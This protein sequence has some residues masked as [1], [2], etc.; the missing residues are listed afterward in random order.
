MGDIRNRCV[1]KEVGL[2]TKKAITGRIMKDWKDSMGIN[3]FDSIR[4]MQEQFQ[5]SL[6]PFLKQQQMIADIT[7]NSGLLKVQEQMTR[8]FSGINMMSEIAKSMKQHS[9]ITQPH[10]S[11]IDAITKSISWQTKFAI[12]QN[13][14]DAI[15]SI[16]RQHEK[17]FGN[18][19]AITDSGKFQ[20]PAITQIN[21]L[22]I[23]LGGISGQLAA[24]A[25]QQKNWAIL[26]DFD[27]VTEQAFE[28][29]ETLD[30]SSEAEQQRQFQI[31]LSLVVT[32]YNKHKTLGLSSLRVIEIFLIVAGLH[33]YYD[34]IQ[35][36]PELATKEDVKQIINGQDSISDFIKI[37][38]EQLKEAKEYRITNRICKV[39]LKPK[40]KTLTLTELPINFDVIVIQIHHKWVYVSYFDPK[41]NLPQ[42]GWIMKKY[43]NQPK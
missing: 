7:R 28:F 34:F 31:L 37:V 14:L 42:T 6:N 22:N 38:N 27:T 29:T 3:A 19:R 18:L 21:N 13:T 43:L 2:H 36:K 15:T 1:Y 41:D 30:S 32:F 11:A 26:N 20:S 39:K 16:N 8:S 5:T 35:T 33:Q 40:V 23:A 24:I 25:A 12:P 9:V 10:F 17:L 4:K